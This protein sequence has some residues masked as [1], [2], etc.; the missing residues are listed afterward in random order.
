MTLGDRIAYALR[1]LGR[2]Q[3]WL[4]DQLE[5]ESPAQV[6]RWVRQG[7]IPRGEA[8]LRVREILG[9]NGHWLMT[10]EG[11]AFTM[12]GEEAAALQRVRDAIDPPQ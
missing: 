7:V 11:D 4:A 10:G 2:T 12:P 5:L 9:V 6:N 8:L 3:T 1:E